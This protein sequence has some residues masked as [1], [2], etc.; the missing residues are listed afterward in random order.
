MGQGLKKDDSFDEEKKKL[1]SKEKEI[2]IETLADISKRVKGSKTFDEFLINSKEKVEPVRVVIRDSNKRCLMWFN[3]KII[4]VVFMILYITGIYVIIGFKDSIMEEIKS[5][6]SLY[7]SNTTRTANETFYDHYNQINL[8]TPKFSLYFLTSSFSGKIFNCIGIYAQS[9]IVLILNTAIFFGIYLFDFHIEPENINEKYSIWQFLYL[10]LMYIL[11]YASIGL[12]SMLPHYIFFT[13]FDKFEDW[14]SNSINMLNYDENENN[15]SKGG[16]GGSFLC[17]YISLLFSMALKYIL[18]QYII[19]HNKED[20]EIFYAALIGCHIIPIILALIFY[21]LFAKIFESNIPKPEDK[22]ESKSGCRLFGC[23]IY[24]ESKDNPLD[25]KCEGIRKGCR[26]CYF[27]CFCYCC[28]CCKC[29]SCN[30]CCCD[31]KTDDELSDVENRDKMICIIYKSSGVISWF[32]DLLTN[33]NVM[34]YCFIMLFLQLINCGFRGSLSSYLRNCEEQKRDII[35]LLGLAGIFLFYFF[36]VLP[37]CICAKFIG[38]QKVDEGSIIGFGLPL[39]LFPASLVSFIFSLLAYYEM[40]DDTIY[41]LI[42]FSIGSI[43]FYL[44]LLKRI[45]SAILPTE[46]L[47]ADFVI[48][49]YIIFWNIFL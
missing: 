23:I 15:K 39:Y 18:N 29:F 6:A 30:N 44:I 20:S 4:G 10:A 36:I 8:E 32:C 35:N 19:V 12:I 16:F 22:K 41:Y 21:F 3:M 47:S 49:I 5:S 43:E 46:F 11:L 33:R 14:Y 48:S 9:I 40:I 31:S 27:N 34:I 45:A 17:F 1:I 26:K 13:A 28:C 38:G 7:L 24:K 2:F 25:I 37:G 42:P